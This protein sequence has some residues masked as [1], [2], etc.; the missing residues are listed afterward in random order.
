MLDFL[1]VEA[2]PLNHLPEPRRDPHIGCSVNDYHLNLF[3]LLSSFYFILQ[4]ALLCSLMVWSTFVTLCNAQCYFMLNE[5][6]PG[7]LSNG[8][9]WL[10]KFIILLQPDRY[11]LLA[12]DGL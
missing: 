9:S 10:F 7:D 4:K 8:K 1:R 2:P 3:I 6:T 12:D 11:K 5:N